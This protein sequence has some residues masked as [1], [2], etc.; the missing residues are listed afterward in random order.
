L[1]ISLL[2]IALAIGFFSGCSSREYYKP[3]EVEGSWKS[4]KSAKE[5]VVSTTTAALLKD[6]F[7]QV[8]SLKTT[9]KPHKD[10]HLVGSSG[11]FVIL[12]K[13]N[14]ELRL[15]DIKSEKE[16]VFSLKKTVASA[17][18]DGEF[19][20]VLFANNEMAVYKLDDKTLYLKEQGDSAIVVNSKI[21]PPLFRDG[22]VLFPTLDGKV[23]IINLQT[24][25][26]LRTVIIDAEK[27]FSNVL[28]FELLEG[29]MV[30]AT[31]NKILSLSQ[32]EKRAT[33]DI[34]SVIRDG[35]FLYV[36]TKQGEVK[37]LD[38]SLN[39]LSS[40]KFAFAHI[41]GLI[42][43]GD[44]IYAAE[45]NGYLIALDKDLEHFKVYKADIDEDSSTYIYDKSFYI[46][47]ELISVE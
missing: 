2:F 21:V 42:A 10:E 13:V 45:R 27:Y 9:I 31:Q 4:S 44:K 32:D 36:A 16:I 24:K 40:K 47:D 5:M 1:K 28:F 14:G 41:L 30:V 26:K 43:S 12:A 34:R 23:V 33:Y 46:G 19:L 25:Q 39:E 17:S 7:V 3:E 22:L 29:K 20:A 11:D 6:G 18:V 15:V 38:S 37:K 8:G 35:S